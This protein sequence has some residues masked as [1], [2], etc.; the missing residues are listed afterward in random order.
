MIFIS[1]ENG[2]EANRN[3]RS[4][5]RAAPPSSVHLVK[6]IFAKLVAKGGFADFAS[7]SLD[8]ALF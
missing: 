4:A 8:T 5:S 1:D 3:A 6:P 2:S 7:E